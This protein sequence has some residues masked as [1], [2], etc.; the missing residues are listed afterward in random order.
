MKSQNFWKSTPAKIL[1]GIMIVAAVL[2]IFRK[3]YS[4]GQWLQ[5]F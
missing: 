3:G 4:F 5:S 1:L 2:F